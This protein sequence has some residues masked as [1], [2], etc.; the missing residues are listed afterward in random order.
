[1]FNTVLFPYLRQVC[2]SQFYILVS[3]KTLNTADW[4]APLYCAFT[5][6]L[7]IMPLHYA[8]HNENA[9]LHLYLSKEN[10]V[11]T[12]YQDQCND[13]WHKVLEVPLN[14]G[15]DL[16]SITNV[17]LFAITLKAHTSLGGNKEQED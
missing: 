10:I 8:T 15:R 6:C 4:F 16:W 11:V 17:A 3:D 12:Y 7:D 5:L 1:M 2:C 9:N 13:H 14:I